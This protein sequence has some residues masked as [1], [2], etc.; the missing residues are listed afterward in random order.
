VPKYRVYLNTV[1]SATV[2]VD[3]PDGM[4]DPEEIVEFAYN[5]GEMPSLSAQGS[6]WGQP[7]SMDLGEWETTVHE[8]GPHKGT[9]YVTDMD[10]KEITGEA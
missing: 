3:V 5:H 10:G 1:A 8:H 2:E 6:G 9:A 7:W 4:T